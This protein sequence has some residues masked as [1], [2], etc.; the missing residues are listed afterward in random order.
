MI[1]ALV[2]DGLRLVPY[3]DEH[4]AQTV[5][6]L[7][8]PQM[9]SGFGLT[10]KV[11]LESHRAWLASNRDILVWAIMDSSGSHSGNILL[12]PEAGR[13][14]AYLQVYVGSRFQ[15]QGVAS[16]ALGAVLTFAFD[17]LGLHRIWLHTLPENAAAAA[18]YVKLGFVREGVEREALPRGDGYADQFRWSLLAQEWERIKGASRA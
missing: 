12:H 4:D 13:R 16:R 8:D 10:R 11:A 2:A 9:Q 6:W 15:R 1:R 14:S 7:N 5:Q 3:G 18:L 17:V